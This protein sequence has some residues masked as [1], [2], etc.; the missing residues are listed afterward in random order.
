MTRRLRYSLTAL[1]TI[2]LVAAV[3][4]SAAQAQYIGRN[5]GRV[6]QSTQGAGSRFQ[7][8]KQYG[9]Q[10]GWGAQSQAKGLATKK[11]S[12]PA[13]DKVRA[14]PAIQLNPYAN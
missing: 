3:A 2:A 11:G 10:V 6:Q 4:S 8:T 7:P 13:K 14:T 5:D 1:A 9:A 12:Q